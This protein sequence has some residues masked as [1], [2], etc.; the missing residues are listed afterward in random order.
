MKDSYVPLLPPQFG[1]FFFFVTCTG[2][3][4]S[5]HKNDN[6]YDTEF[7]ELI[8]TQKPNDRQLRQWQKS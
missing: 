7:A 6:A 3:P 8:T 2:N 5:C 1:A 4:N